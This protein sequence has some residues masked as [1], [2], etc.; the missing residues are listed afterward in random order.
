MAIEKQNNK[1]K[2]IFKQPKVVWAVF[3]SAVISF[4]GLGLVDP[5]LPVIS[6]DL[7]ASQTEVALL[8][9]TYST[10]M[11][12]AMLV[13]DIISSKLGIKKTLLSGV[14]IIAMFSVLCGYSNN[15]W[16]II[17]LRMGWGFGNALFVAV[18]LTAILIFSGNDHHS[19]IILY[20]TAVGLGF[21]MGPLIGGILGGML[22]KYP[23]YGVGV[24]MFLGFILLIV[25]LPKS[26]E[27]KKIMETNDN[28]T[29]KNK[30]ILDP[31]RLMG[32]RPVAVLGIF[33]FLYNFGFFTLF[34]YSPFVMGLNAEAIG[35]VFLGW[36]ILVALSSI[37]MAPKIRD[38]F[39]TFKSIYYILSLF[40]VI[41]FI[42]G[43]YTDTVSILIISI[44]LSGIL[45]GNINTLLTTAMMKI[46]GDD[47]STTSAAYNFI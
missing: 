13:T 23:F 19:S 18:A 2:D 7:G 39:G 32:K 31:F 5:I 24:L 26:K 20:E 10:I 44:I 6:Q 3:F 27:I 22:W 21:S 34:A 25:L 12:I 8:F 45:I 16:T 11:A 35:L 37:F 17:F 47:R 30:S 42:M 36:G 41:L 4:M 46:G 29:S 1:I 28:V 9:T 40:V 43:I 15:I 33:G 38:K 14:A